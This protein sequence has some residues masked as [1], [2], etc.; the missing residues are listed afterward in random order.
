MS[1]PRETRWV[2][3]VY[4]DRRYLD[5]A[6]HAVRMQSIATGAVTTWCG[7]YLLLSTPAKAANRLVPANDGQIRSDVRTCEPCKRIE[8]DTRTGTR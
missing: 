3:R 4:D 6:R 1:P 8:W 5:G 2:R 7:R